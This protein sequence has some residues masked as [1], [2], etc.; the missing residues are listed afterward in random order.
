[1]MLQSGAHLGRQDFEE[2]KRCAK[3]GSD[4]QG[5]P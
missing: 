5:G 2:A 1:M 3:A 4:F